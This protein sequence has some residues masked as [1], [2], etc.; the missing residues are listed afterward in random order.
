MFMRLERTSRRAT[1]A[2]ERRKPPRACTGDTTNKT[3]GIEVWT[4]L[5]AATCVCDKERGKSYQRMSRRTAY[6]V[7]TRLISIVLRV[8][9]VWVVGSGSSVCRLF[10]VV[11]HALY[12]H[13]SLRQFGLELLV[14]EERGLVVAPQQQGRVGRVAQAGN[15]RTGASGAVC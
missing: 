5:Q 7:Q 8:A 3:G 15:G 13:L 10:D 1:C 9:I 2:G 6:L 14:G 12:L 4:T 11:M